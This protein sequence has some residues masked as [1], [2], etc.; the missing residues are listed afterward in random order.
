MHHQRPVILP[1]DR[2][3]PRLHGVVVF[4]GSAIFR[5]DLSH[6]GGKRSLG[7]AAGCWYRWEEHAPRWVVR[8]AV[9]QFEIG[10]MRLALVF[11]ADKRGGVTSPLECVGHN[12][13]D[14][15]LAEPDAVVSKWNE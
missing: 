10:Q 11:D 5:V 13:R 4:R 9:R 7:I 1:D 8:V 6:G 15:L 14:R 2:A 12:Q 3:R